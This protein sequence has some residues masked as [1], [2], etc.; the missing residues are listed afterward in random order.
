MFNFLYSGIQKFKHH[1]K[2]YFPDRHTIIGSE[3]YFPGYDFKFVFK[4]VLF[5]SQKILK[6]TFWNLMKKEYVTFILKSK[7]III[8][9]K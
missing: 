9:I 8:S 2:I 4:K 3:K 1:F 5:R 7:K 6:S